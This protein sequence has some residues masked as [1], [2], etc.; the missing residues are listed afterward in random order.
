VDLT[1]SARAGS[2]SRPGRRV[3][4]AVVI[5]L[6]AGCGGDDDGDTSSTSAAKP[7][8]IS[9]E[10][11]SKVPLGTPRSRVERALGEPY[12]KQETKPYGVVHQC[13]RYRGIA[14]NGHVDP[15]NEFRLCYNGKDRLS[16]KS[17]API[18]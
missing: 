4:L 2:T 14:P 17:T 18:R 7:A 15:V 6:L 1:H 5:A 10:Q 12:R 13:Y 16:V 11:L 9:A 8:A 3:Y